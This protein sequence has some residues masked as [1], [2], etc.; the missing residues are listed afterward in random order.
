[1]RTADR[2]GRAAGAGAQAGAGGHHSSESKE[3]EMNVELGELQST[4]GRGRVSEGGNSR[5]NVSQVASWT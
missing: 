3:A 2:P 4:V 1:M 5:E